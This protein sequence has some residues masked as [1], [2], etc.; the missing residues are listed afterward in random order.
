[1]KK[2]PLI[3]LTGPTAVGKTE[4]S[5]ALAKAVNG[6]I[7]SADSMQVYKY[8]DIG[9]A[10]ITK[11]E[12]QGVKHYL[13]D[14]IEPSEGFDVA[15]FKSMATN[16]IQK[17]R[18]NGHIPVVVGGTGFYIQ[19]IT[20]DIDFTQAEQED[21][22]RQELEQLAAEKGNEYLHQMLLNVDPVSAGEI[23]ANNVKRVIRALEFYHQNQSPISAHNQEQKEHETP[24][25]LAYFVLNVPR[26]LLYKRIDDRIDEM[27]KD[28]L[29]EEVQKLKDMGYHRGMVSMQGLGYKEIL[30]YLDGEYPLE[31][32]VRILKRDTRHF[33]KRQLTWFRRE[34]D[35]IWM[36]KDEFD[37]NEDR[38]LDEMLKVCRDRGIL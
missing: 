21:G 37:Y 33:A 19:A 25:N 24:Y 35:T 29:L 38:I 8:M 23:H 16:A 30:A 28:G 13:V 15:R 27:L 14:E 4:L 12:M 22:Y 34:K 7:I 9:T 3:I 18:E 2:E 36:N 26:E 11:E 10:K 5:I 17:I 6:E 20:K 31:E 32:A 1:M